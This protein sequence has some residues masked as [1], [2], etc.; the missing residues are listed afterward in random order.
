[1]LP[2]ELEPLTDTEI[3]HEG[4]LRQLIVEAIQS[5]GGRSADEAKAY[6]EKMK[7]EKRYQRDVY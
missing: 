6:V 5:A 1:M 4:R 2:L 7:T 3:A